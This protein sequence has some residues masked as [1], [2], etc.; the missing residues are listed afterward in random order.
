VTAGDAVFLAFSD[1]LQAYV[2]SVTVV[3]DVCFKYFHLDVAYVAMAIHACVQEHVSSASPVFRRML[4][5]FYLD[6][7]YVG[8]DYVASVYSECFIWFRCMLQLFH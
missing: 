7:A 6:V 1:M 3:S 4:Q 2:S 8:N 5:V